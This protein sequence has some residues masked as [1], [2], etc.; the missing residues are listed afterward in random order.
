MKLEISSSEPEY[1][2]P[3]RVHWLVLLGVSVILDFIIDYY[4]PKPFQEILTSLA[5]DG[6][7]FYLCLWI[8]KL[9]HESLSPFWCDV[10]VV[11]E[12]AFSAMSIGQHPSAHIQVISSILGFASAVLG[13]ATIF[14]IR[15]DLVKHYSEREDFT[16]V[17]G[18]FMSFFF[19]FFYFQYHLYDIA[20]QK[21][22]ER[23]S[24]AT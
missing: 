22:K 20:E 17:L 19:S 7:A 1:P 3:P 11:V 13:I 2:P 5:V 9:D 21:L 23:N 18:P 4:A 14:L 6:W 15:R 16:L 24:V 8:R 12:L 10:Y